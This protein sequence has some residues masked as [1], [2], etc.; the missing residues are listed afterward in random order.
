MQCQSADEA[1]LEVVHVVVPG[2]LLADGVALL[3]M[4]VGSMCCSCI[5]E[6]PPQKL[7]QK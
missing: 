7:P 1:D 3:L 5:V 2:D 6:L 4:V